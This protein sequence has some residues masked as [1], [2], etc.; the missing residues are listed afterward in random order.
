MKPITSR[1]TSSILWILVLVAVAACQNGVFNDG[2]DDDENACVGPLGP[3]M[4]SSEI[5][6][7]AACCSAEMGKA[8]CLPD[9]NTPDVIKGFLAACDSGG[10]C[11]PDSMLATGGSV[12]PAT[13]TAFGGEG[14]CLSR[15]IPQVAENAGLLQPDTCAGADELC[16]PCISPLDNKPTGA[17]DLLTQA[18]CV[19]EDFGEGS[20][21][22]SATACDDPA[23]C[24][25]EASCPPV[26]DVATLMSCAP[27]AHCIDSAV[28][29]DPALRARLATCAGGKVCVPDAFLATGGKFT[30]KT[31]NSL[32]G[33]EG[34]CMSRAIP[35]VKAREDQLPQDTCTTNERCAPCFD[36]ITGMDTGVCKLSC[37]TGPTKPAVQL[38]ACC[39]MKA[40]CVPA[41]AIPD[42]QEAYLGQDTCTAQNLC[43]PDQLLLD[44]P[45]PACT[46]NGLFIGQ[47][48]GVCLSDCLDF[49]F[50]GEFLDRGNCMAGYTCAPCEMFGEPTGAP[51][52]PM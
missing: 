46:A 50:E 12:P 13:C 31:C 43:V 25:Y 11:I 14:V 7:M 22:G 30:P 49:G 15:C 47:Y 33:A 52:C 45:T 39:G 27:D 5:R 42:D 20:G 48:T 26:I 18:R 35:E 29:A 44:Q 41:T 19:G 23:T 34:R 32:A 28:V 6:A 4:S 37:D 17:C 16:V 24:N 21:S 9:A 36:P 40:H 1:F 51:G 2:D 3:P 8:H 10:Y 38:A